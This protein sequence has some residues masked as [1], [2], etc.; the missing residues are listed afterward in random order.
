[1]KESIDDLTNQAIDLV[2]DN[3]ALQDRIVKPLK[4]KILPYAA[5]A[6]LTNVAILILLVYLALRLRVLQTPM[7]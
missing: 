4:R 7:I 1:M 6:A 2:L 5:C 3:D